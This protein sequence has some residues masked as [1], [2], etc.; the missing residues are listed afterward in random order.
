MEV[1]KVLLQTQ[2]EKCETVKSIK[3]KKYS[4][5]GANVIID[6]ITDI[7]VINQDTVAKLKPV[8]Y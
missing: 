7:F 3:K 5:L 2:M 4:S 6:M 1:L 8:C